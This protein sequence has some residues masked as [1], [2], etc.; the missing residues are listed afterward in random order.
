MS[1]SR[2]F[3]RDA[4]KKEQGSNK[5]QRAWE[6]SQIKRYGFKAWWDMRVSCDPK[7]RRAATLVK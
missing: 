1:I 4:M 5:I 2:Q 6:A 7:R 3:R